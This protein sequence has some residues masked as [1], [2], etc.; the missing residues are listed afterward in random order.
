MTKQYMSSYLCKRPCP[1]AIALSAIFLLAPLGREGPLC[2]RHNHDLCARHTLCM[3]Q[4]L[5]NNTQSFS[6]SLSR[7]LC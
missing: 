4:L 1:F 5:V 7:F 6:L 2:Y 3:M